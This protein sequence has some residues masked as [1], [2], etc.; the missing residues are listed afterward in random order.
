MKIFA[1]NHTWRL[2]LLCLLHAIYV[3]LSGM[4]FV[5]I[6]L[7]TNE[8]FD[9]EAISVGVAFLVCVAIP[10]LIGVAMTKA[11]KTKS[12]LISLPIQFIIS[13]GIQ[14]MGIGMTSDQF[15]T[16]IITAIICLVFQSVGVGIKLVLLKRQFTK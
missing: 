1:D 2:S 12:W 15:T 16:Q 14:S 4:I 6:G 7:L 5:M 10:L 3:A 13:V 9:V 11:T 8:M